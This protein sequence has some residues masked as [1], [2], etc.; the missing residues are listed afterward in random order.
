VARTLGRPLGELSA[1]V[2]FAAPDGSL[3]AG[4][5]MEAIDAVRIGIPVAVIQQGAG[6]VE[7]TGLRFLPY[8]LR[9]PYRTALV[10]V[11]EQIDAA[12]MLAVDEP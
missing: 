12:E 10:V 3:G 6:L 11:G 7:L 9:T 8:R 1:V 5:L 4:C 2:V